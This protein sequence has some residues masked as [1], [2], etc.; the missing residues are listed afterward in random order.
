[1]PRSSKGTW[2]L[3]SFKVT[4]VKVTSKGIKMQ[5]VCCQKAKVQELDRF[6][7][8]ETKMQLEVFLLLQTVI[9]KMIMS[10]DNFYVTRNR[11][12]HTPKQPTNW[13]RNSM[14][15]W[16]GNMWHV[17][18][19]INKED[20]QN[21]NRSLRNNSFVLKRCVVL[22]CHRKGRW[23][24]FRSESLITLCFSIEGHSWLRRS[25]NL[26][27]EWW[28]RQCIDISQQAMVRQLLA[29]CARLV[30]GDCSALRRGAFPLKNHSVAQLLSQ[31]MALAIGACLL[32]T[33][34][35]PAEE[36]FQL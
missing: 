33:N 12:S 36:C 22:L 24:R 32:T 5:R 11:S 14:T 2:L 28:T 25:S 8:T 16:E 13:Y 1:M 7:R 9:G 30:P 21:Y 15:Y 4:V 6:F 26:K 34:I 23:K 35:G 17:W 20:R 29:S 3:F 10:S 18:G 27:R 31:K 19:K